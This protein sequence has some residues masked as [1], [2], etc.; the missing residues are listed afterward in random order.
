MTR[1]VRV[2]F[3]L[4]VQAGGD[5]IGAGMGAS[6]SHIRIQSVLLSNILFS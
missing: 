1:P 6:T 2:T 3:C 5:G 4:G